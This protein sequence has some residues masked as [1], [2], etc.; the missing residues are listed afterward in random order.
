MLAAQPLGAILRDTHK[1]IDRTDQA[2]PPAGNLHNRR[3]Y[4]FMKRAEIRHLAMLFAV[5]GLQLPVE[6]GKD[7]GRYLG[8]R[9]PPQ[10]FVAL[11]RMPTILRHLGDVRT[12]RVL[13]PTTRIGRHLIRP[14]EATAGFKNSAGQ[15]QC[16]FEN[17]RAQRRLQARRLRGDQ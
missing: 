3:I 4:L 16:I 12:G 6:R 14:F 5:I 10:I 8:Q 15:V 17:A 9:Q 11:D 2:I 1:V 13:V 7:L